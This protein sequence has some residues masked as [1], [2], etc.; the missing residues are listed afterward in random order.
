M[1]EETRKEQRYRCLTCNETFTVKA[2][3]KPRC[4]SCMSIHSVEPI[5]EKGGFKLPRW[6]RH[7]AAALGIA[8]LAVGG[9]FV[10]ERFSG[11]E[12][13]TT[14][15][16]TKLGAVESERLA[17]FLA[18]EQ[19]D[20]DNRADPFESDEALA[21]FARK[22]RGLGGPRGKAEGIY[23]AMLEYKSKGGYRALVPRQPRKT[24]VMNAEETFKAATGAGKPEIYSLETAILFTKAARLAGLPAVVAEIVDYDGLKAPLDPSGNFGHFASAVFTSGGYEGPFVIFDLHQ[25]RTQDGQDTHAIPLTDPQVVAQF[26]GHEAAY[27]VSVKFDVKN[28]LIKLE[29]ALILAPDSVQLH[30]LQAL[31][32]MTSGGIEEG[33]AELRKA[34]QTRNDPQRMVKW[35]ALMLADDEVEDAMA[36]IRKAIDL[37]PDY[38]LAHA[39]LAMAY[40]AD[41]EN[42]EAEHELA[43]ARKMDPEDPLLP[44]YESNFYLVTG[45]AADALRAAERAWEENYHDPQTG[46]LLAGIYAQTGHKEEMRKILQEIRANENLPSELLA[47]I[48]EQ[49][50]QMTYVDEEGEDEE[51]EEGEEE[52]LPSLEKPGIGEKPQE[53]FL[54]GKG[55]SGLDMQDPFGGMSLKKGGGLLSGGSK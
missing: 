41:G 5:D 6:W 53:G 1:A 40:L 39:S 36:E 42:D 21:S 46:L 31:I 38:A 19:I 37:M 8:V 47:L 10:Y 23:N 45:R 17:K 34:M 16:P 25:G 4:P 24:I 48:D 3:R 54:T 49:L 7:A 27:L 22:H 30:T 51:E 15:D 35:G 44:V 29:D 12:A 55:G 26:L 2:G 18:D 13:P 32:Y 14:A 11:S 50:G 33:K 9:F 52:A 28:A 20:A 43:L